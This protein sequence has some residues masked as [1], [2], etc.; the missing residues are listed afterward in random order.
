MKEIFQIMLNVSMFA[1]VAGTMISIGLGLTFSQVVKPFK[2]IK[3]VTLS[4]FSNFLIVPLF[5]YGLVSVIPVSEGV[6]I[7][8]MLLSIG[9]G[10]P[11][12]PMIVGFAKGPVGGAVGLM[13]LLILATIVLMPIIVPML[14]PSAQVTVWEIA[15]SLVYSMLIPLVLALL[16]KARFSD[17][18]ARIQP[19]CQKLTN[20]SILILIIALVYLYTEVIISAAAVIPI[21]LLFFLGAAAIGFVSGGRNS[22]ARLS[23][24]VGTGLRNPPVAM[25]VANQYFSAEPMAAIVPLLIVIVGLSILIPLSRIIGNKV[26]KNKSTLSPSL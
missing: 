24:A 18:A 5:A 11:F 14:F 19:L 1:F 10:A 7:G 8:I 4:L 9:G 21:I 2:D 13:L 23:L 15:K 26:A 17:I 16:F 20:L 6:R 22:G 12:I 25:L 3:L